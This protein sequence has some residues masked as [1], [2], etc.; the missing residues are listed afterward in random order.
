MSERWRLGMGLVAAALLLFAVALLAHR[1]ASFDSVRDHSSLRR[2]PWGVAA[3]R[4]L[5]ERS[6]V[7]TATWDRPLTELDADVQMLVILAPV[8]DIAPGELDALLAWLRA[9]GRLVVAATARSSPGGALA[10]EPD[11]SDDLLRRLGLSASPAPRAD[12]TVAPVAEDPV[13]ADVRALR[14]PGGLRL[15]TRGERGERGP[16]SAVVLVGE[17]DGAAVMAVTVGRGRAL[18]LAEAEMLA[19]A[20]LRRDDNVVLAANLVFAGGAPARV[21]FDEYHHG[22]RG[23]EPEPERTVD[24]R[25]LRNAALALLAVL[26]VFAVGR[27][28]RF[29]APRGGTPD[30]RP[31]AA[32]YVRAYALMYARAGAAGAAAGMLHRRLRHEL[33]RAAGLPVSADDARL[34]AELEHRGVSSEG[35][36]ALL[37]HLRDAADRP[38]TGR[39]L[40]ELAR[41]VAD[42]ERKL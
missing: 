11:A 30:R 21:H 15:S 2:N 5:V 22:V 34:A 26:I 24:V 3:W 25:P 38:L 32:D 31:R 18:A 41:A 12:A 37:T 39:E 13:T 40:V 8:H 9:G 42:Y 10:A 16:S 33:A 19:N 6:G 27:G 17:G 23:G 1:H 36:R 4:A 7:P 20:V 35:L 29:G 14:V 28:R